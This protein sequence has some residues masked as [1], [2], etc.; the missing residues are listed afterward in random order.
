MYAN[1]NV[2]NPMRYKNGNFPNKMNTIKY[3]LNT[4]TAKVKMYNAGEM[5]FWNIIASKISKCKVSSNQ[6]NAQ[7]KKH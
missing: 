5:T 3:V 7:I 1:Q 4:K 2:N 6:N